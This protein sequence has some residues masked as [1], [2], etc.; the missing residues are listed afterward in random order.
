MSRIAPNELERERE[1]KGKR[2]ALE[3]GQRSAVPF[4]CAVKF[5]GQLFLKGRI[6]MAA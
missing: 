6:I 5:K 4:V 1:R 2:I 3:E